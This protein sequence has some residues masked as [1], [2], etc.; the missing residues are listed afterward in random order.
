MK[1]RGYQKRAIRRCVDNFQKSKRVALIMP[2]GAGKTV[3]ASSICG[4][5]DNIL[6]LAHRKELLLQA[7]KSLSRLNLNFETLSTSSKK[8][9]NKHYDLVVIDEFHHEACD[10]YR[11]LTEQLSYKRLLGIT[12][13]RYRLDRIPLRFDSLVEAVTHREL[14]QAGYLVPSRLF[15]VRVE[16][17]HVGT[18]VKFVN[19]HNTGPTIFFVRDLWTAVAVKRHLKMPSE[20]IDG[21]S[22]N[23]KKH[24]EDF[25]N[26]KVKCLV[27]CMV[28]TEGVDLPICKTV[29]LGRPTYSP[30]LLLQMIGRAVRIHPSKN[31]CNII[32]PAFLYHKKKR[33]ANRTTDSDYIRVSDVHHSE[34]KYIVT[35]SAKKMRIQRVIRGCA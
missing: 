17:D 20:V 15:R 16:D 34:D 6:W 25:I 1:L 22:S 11:R 14:V 35:P 10:T 9:P 12:A 29:V 3:V 2:T 8:I 7:E 13:T 18:L 32:E 28:L 23:R 30:T 19:T 21:A 33:R 31:H 27:S 5:F 4:H 26:G 24:L